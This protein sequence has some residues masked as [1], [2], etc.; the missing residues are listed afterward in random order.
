MEINKIEVLKD[1]LKPKLVYNIQ[2]FLGF[3]NFY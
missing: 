1:L 3:V 2:V